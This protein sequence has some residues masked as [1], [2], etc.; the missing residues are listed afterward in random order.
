[1]S[2]SGLLV[3]TQPQV[4]RMGKGVSWPGGSGTNKSR[5]TTESQER[6]A[7][8]P[9]GCGVPATGKTNK[10]ALG[11]SCTC[12]HLGRGQAVTATCTENQGHSRGA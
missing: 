12:L 6:N 4:H 11:S 3:D 10:A 7:A 1:M 9:P 2:L 8:V 5:Y